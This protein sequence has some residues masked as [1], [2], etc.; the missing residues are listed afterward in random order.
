MIF[1][2]AALSGES[3]SPVRDIAFMVIVGAFVLYVKL[4]AAKKKKSAQK[5]KTSKKRI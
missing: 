4:N 1:G 3:D 2:N 5:Q